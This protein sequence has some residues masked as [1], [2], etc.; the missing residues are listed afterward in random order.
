MVWWSIRF[1]VKQAI[2]RNTQQWFHGLICRVNRRS[3]RGTG[4]VAVEIQYIAKWRAIVCVDSS[5]DSSFLSS[6]VHTH[7][8][9]PGYWKAS[10]GANS[11]SWSP[12]Y[13]ASYLWVIVCCSHA[14][15]HKHID[16]FFG[17]TFQ[18][19][20]ADGDSSDERRTH[21]ARLFTTGFRHQLLNKL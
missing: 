21:R 19:K 7:T 6:H 17:Q 3:P 5:R 4:S 1:K 2:E 18:E 16:I 15:A 13:D 12:D 8:R 20:Q 10:R 9:P 14:G 11:N